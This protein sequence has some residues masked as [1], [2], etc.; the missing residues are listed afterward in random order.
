MQKPAPVDLHPLL[1]DRW[2]P[3]AFSTQPVDEPVLRRLL[4][5]ARW[6]PSCFNEQPWRLL[7]A[8]HREPDAHRALLEA[9]M[10]GNRVWA[11][12]AP[13]LILTFARQTFSHNDAPNPHAW[14]DVGLA[15]AQLTAQASAEGLVVHQ[16]AGIRRDH[17]VETFAIPEPYVPVTGLAVGHPGDAADLPE[18][19]R[20]RE[21]GPRARRPLSELAFTGAWGAAR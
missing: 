14:H 10:E 7:V 1:R 6:A 4:E 16:M 19:L 11:H 20:E 18:P 17:I 13:V 15:M 3:R 8:T 2:S 21:L 5:A 9:L 12:R